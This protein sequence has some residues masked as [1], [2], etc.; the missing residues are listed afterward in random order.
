[1]WGNPIKGTWFQL[2]LPDYTNIS[3]RRQI[4]CKVTANEENVVNCVVILP[5]NNTMIIFV[6]QN[7]SSIV[8]TIYTPVYY[9]LNL[10]DNKIVDP[11][12]LGT[13]MA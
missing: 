11:V 3:A 8:Y 2:Q 6:K 10:R 5:N 1:M 9:A 7:Y 12:F 4:N 13:P